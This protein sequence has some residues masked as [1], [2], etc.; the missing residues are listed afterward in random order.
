MGEWRRLNAEVHLAV[1]R[2][3]AGDA[4][5][6]RAM[7][8]LKAHHQPALLMGA[9]AGVGV[10]MWWGRRGARSAP[11]PGASHAPQPSSQA[12]RDERLRLPAWLPW[13]VG[14]MPAVMHHVVAPAVAP[15][16]RRWVTHP[17]SLSAAVALVR[18]AADVFTKRR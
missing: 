17:L 1:A 3:H 8:E 12:V 2:V 6:A 7:G 4:R 5:A 13:V 9:V 15:A 10:L 16:W 11:I 18:R 14:A